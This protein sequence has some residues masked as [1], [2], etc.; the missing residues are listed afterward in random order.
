M[1]TSLPWLWLND[2]DY[3]D[4]MGGCGNF[5]AWI[6]MTAYRIRQTEPHSV[7]VGLTRGI[8]ISSTV[9]GS[10]FSTSGA[11][12]HAEGVSLWQF[13]NAILRRL[14]KPSDD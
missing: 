5:S 9:E 3:G 10:V 7:P 4:K 13:K 1:L 8:C 12:M 6:I 11:L 2:G 14:S